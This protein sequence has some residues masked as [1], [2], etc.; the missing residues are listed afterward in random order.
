[1]EPLSPAVLKKTTKAYQKNHGD[2]RRTALDLGIKPRSCQERIAR[3]KEEGFLTAP[4]EKAIPKKEWTPKEVLEAGEL[5]EVWKLNHHNVSGTARALNMSRETFRFKLDKALRIKGLDKAALLAVNLPERMNLT[6]T[7]VQYGPNGEILNEW[8]RLKPEADF[9]ETVA[10]ELCKIVDGKSPV[11]PVPPRPVISDFMLEIPLFDVHFGKYAW[12]EETGTDFDLKLCEALTV[13]TVSRM[14]AEAGEFGSALLVIGG[15]FLHADTRDAVTPKGKNLLDVDSRY[16]KVWEVATQ[17]L[18]KCIALL[19]SKCNNVK[20]VVI[21]GNHDF[22]SMFHLMRFLTAFY[23]TQPQ[24]E[25]IN[26]PRTRQYVHWGI[27]LIGIAHGDV[28]KMKDFPSLMALEMPG[29]W[30]E[31]T[32]RTWHLGHLHKQMSDTRHG[33]LVEHLE[34]LTA[35]DAWHYQMGFVGSPRRISGFMWHKKWG[36]KRRLYVSTG[37]VT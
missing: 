19:S 21:P 34:S 11:L 13:G 12:S 6:K 16:F 7:T 9:L 23:H 15:D 33:V 4:V 1:M 32:E 30:A 17:A 20:I 36:L 14:V 8:R 25:V 37:E 5:I 28:M 22:E 18:H 31:T 35:T 24:I 2:M 27:N 29:A 10:N 26:N 3:A